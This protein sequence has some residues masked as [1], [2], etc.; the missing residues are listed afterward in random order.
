MKNQQLDSIRM[1]SKALTSQS[2]GVCVLTNIEHRECCC[3]NKILG[4]LLELPVNRKR[5]GMTSPFGN[6]LKAYFSLS[7][8]VVLVSNSFCRSFHIFNSIQSWKFE[9]IAK[10][11]VDCC[12]TRTYCIRNRMKLLFIPQ[13]LLICFNLL[14]VTFFNKKFHWS[15]LMISN[16][17]WKPI[18]FNDNF[19][20][21][22]F[23]TRSVE[24]F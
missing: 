15:L 9:L 21:T 20:E 11:Q 24:A 14:N 23:L 5:I 16:F 8:T 3:S 10:R 13:P 4:I 22:L 6:G 12:N 7:I 2:N 1:D 18:R 17:I 19:I